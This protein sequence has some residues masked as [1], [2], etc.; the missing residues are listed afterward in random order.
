LTDLLV[1]TRTKKERK[2]RKKFQNVQR[3]KR[4]VLARSSFPAPPGGHSHSIIIALKG[5]AASA[6]MQ[7]MHQ[8]A[9]KKSI[10]KRNTKMTTTSK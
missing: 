4:Q 6:E 9:K 1:D 8:S 7:S 2:K 10:Y 5:P 3:T